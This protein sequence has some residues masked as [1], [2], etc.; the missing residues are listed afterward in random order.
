MGQYF[1]IGIGAKRQLQYTIRPTS[2]INC[3]PKEA[4]TMPVSCAAIICVRNEE[5]YLENTLE[6]LVSQGIDVAIIDHESDDNSL[7]ICRQYL[8]AGVIRIDALEWRGEY[9]QTAQLTAKANIAKRLGHDWILHTDADEWLQSPRESESLLEGI[10]R[11]DRLGFNAIDFDEFVF[12]PVGSQENQSSATYPK[13]LHYYYFAPFPNRLMR[14]WRREAEFNNVSSGGHQ[15]KGAKLCL[16]EEKFILRHYIALSQEHAIKKYVGRV[17]S[18]G[19]L[20]KRW[21][22]NR[23]GLTAKQMKLPDSGVLKK[24]PNWRSKSFDRSK[25]LDKHYWQWE[26]NGV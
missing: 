12:L 18:K 10:S 16:A 5:R 24:L 3:R 4:P 17:F 7:S 20:E 21:H 9:D 11:L 26:R 1:F 6:Y 13:F 2:A 22:G 25:P 15:L 19:D 8:G 14:A 23:L